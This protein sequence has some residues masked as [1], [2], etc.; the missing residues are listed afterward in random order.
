MRT[1]RRAVYVTAFACLLALW[2]FPS[3]A[4]ATIAEQRARLPPAAECAGENVAGIWRSHQFVPTYQEWGI[5]TLTIRRVPGHPEQLVGRILSRGWDGGP[6][7]AEPPPCE[8]Q[9]G[10]DWTVEMDGRGTIQND[11]EI[12][13][14]GVGQW[15]LIDARCG[16]GP[17]GYNLDQFRGTI[18]PAI[19]EFQS[20]NND[21]GRYIN[22]PTVFRRIA[23]LPSEYA[24]SPTVRPTPPAF[25][26]DL[27]GGCGR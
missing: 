7:D 8:R 18:D 12:H 4:P 10:W 14:G 5:F 17:A 25:Y 2:F 15:R 26:P 1:R 16:R 3:R 13:F 20:V 23:C 9:N 6:D 19:L 21:G 24:E 22:V 11:V 27:P